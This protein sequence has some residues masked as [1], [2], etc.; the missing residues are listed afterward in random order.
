MY[1]VCPSCSAEVDHYTSEEI[2]CQSSIRLRA[3]PY[4]IPAEYT[5]ESLR[6]Q[7]FSKCSDNFRGCYG[8]IIEQVSNM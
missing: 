4:K 1:E 7:K 8:Y 3:I 2:R 5:L 6:E